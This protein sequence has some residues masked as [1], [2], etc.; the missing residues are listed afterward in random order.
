MTK[1]PA[2]T[3]AEL[4]SRLEELGI[5]TTT[6]EHAAVFTVA[7]SAELHRQLPGGHTKNLFLK[8]HKDR[9]ERDYQQPLLE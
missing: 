7:E 3:R 9:L 8:D 6:E 5:A 4:M 1:A 2:K